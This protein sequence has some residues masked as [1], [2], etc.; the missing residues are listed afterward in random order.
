MRQIVVGI[1]ARTHRAQALIGAIG[2]TVAFALPADAQTVSG[3]VTLQE[4]P[5]ETT[6]DLRDVVAWLTPLDGAPRAAA[7]VSGE[8]LMQGRQYRPKVV[9]VS[10][11]GTV[12]FPNKDGFNHNV[13]SKSPTAP[14]D[15]GLYG[16]GQTKGQAFKATG[17]H[18]IYCNVHPRMLGYVVVVPSAW[19]AQAGDDGRFV[20]ERVPAGRYALTY[21]HSRASAVTDTVV[22]TA[23]GAAL[24]RRALDARGYKYMQ[25]TDKTGKQYKSATGD[26]Y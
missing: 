21:W 11:G 20:I 5:G 19:W 22:V 24:G 25:H 7:G 9:V 23:Q 13:F 14:F 18:A 8:M 1:R 10:P 26:R 15:L 3:Q 17:A 12:R 6:S 2:L 4:R 16:R